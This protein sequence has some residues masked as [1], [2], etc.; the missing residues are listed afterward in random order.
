M[1]RVLVIGSY[2]PSLLNFRGPLL[3][4]MIAAGHEVHAAA[5]DM[6][7]SFRAGLSAL[8]VTAHDII[9]AR[10]GLNPIQDL[11][12]LRSLRSLIKRE[13]PDLVLTYTIK[14]NIWGAFAAS[15][16]GVP[17][18]AMVTG[19]GFAFTDSN[20]QKQPLLRRIVR[21]LYRAATSCN[22]A[23]IFQNPDDR[24]DFIA[25]G[26]LKDPHKARMVNGSGVDLDYYEPSLVPQGAH[27]LMISRLLRCKGVAEYAQAAA[28]VKDRF[29][30]ATFTL[31]GYFDEG[32]DGITAAEM[33]AWQ[34]QG[35][36]Y[37]GPSSDVRPALAAS[38]VYVLPSYREG[39]PR[40]VLEAMATGRA[41]LTSDAPGCRETVIDTQTGFLVPV[42]DVDGLAKRMQ[43]MI[44]NP[45]LRAQM[46]A[47]SL[48]LARE[49]YDVHKVNHTMLDHLGLLP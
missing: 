8:G 12:S 39:T 9:L 16:C 26:C 30:Q 17:S 23:V 40:S 48:N 28:Q 5:P 43:Q 7:H 33:D 18:Y 22:T 11:R 1:T 32:P 34:A 20:T 46:G 25:E 38:S 36:N 49:K 13:Q 41:I 47:A 35:L 19:L 15:L 44:K 24:D 2:A 6:E 21:R 45:N 31:V 3:Q 27:F 37:I 14:P 42:R 4:A 10:T 29:P